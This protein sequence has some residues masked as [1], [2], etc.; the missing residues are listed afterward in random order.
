MSPA[1][2]NEKNGSLTLKAGA[3]MQTV[4]YRYA[5]ASSAICNGV[6]SLLQIKFNHF[7]N[8]VP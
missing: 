3:E 5:S 4:S 2:N 8:S 7:P 6:G 1:T